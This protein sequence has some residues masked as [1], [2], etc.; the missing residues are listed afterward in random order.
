MRF[1]KPLV[2]L[3]GA[4]T[5][6][7]LLWK[8]DPRVIWGL[9]RQVGWGM[10]VIVPLHAVDHIFNSLGWRY[11]FAEDGDRYSLW[12]LFKVRIAGDG[13]NYLTPSATIAGE[14][15][16]PA[17]LMERSASASDSKRLMGEAVSS[18]VVA[19][20]SQ[21]LSQAVFVL[22]GLALVVKTKVA[23]VEDSERM[24]LVGGGVILAVLLG[25]GIY[26]LLNRG[27]LK[28]RRNS[29]EEDRSWW[30]FRALW[31]QISGYF[32]DN[33]VRFILSVFY[34]TLGYLWGAVEAYL[35]C[36]YLG[37]PVSV[38]IAVAIE[39][40]SSMIDGMAFMVPAKIGTQEAGKTAVFV[41]LGLPASQGLAFG[42]VRHVR[43]LI[44]A[45]AGFLVYAG[46]RRSLKSLLPAKKRPLHEA[47][48]VTP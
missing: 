2:I 10:A 12:E 15:I 43:E 7:L 47:G 35:V 11:A 24:F 36:L 31:D 21:A 5:L 32:R 13:V 46:H 34:F 33:P 30:N 23:V 26:G 3:A 1:F 29:P 18:V 8:L 44:W 14:V 45:G 19:K 40:L 48:A 6:L 9:L 27:R 20:F 37:L 17:M 16:R 38:L 28:T 41:A 22:L 4:A 42:I 39:S 25:F